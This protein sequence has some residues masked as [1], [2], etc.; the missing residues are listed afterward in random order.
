MS[1][2]IGVASVAASALKETG[3][4][5]IPVNALQFG[6]VA[7]AATVLAAD[8]KGVNAMQGM[9]KRFSDNLLNYSTAKSETNKLLL[10]MRQSLSDVIEGN[11]KVKGAKHEIELAF[12]FEPNNPV[13]KDLDN[14]VGNLQ[15]NFKSLSSLLDSAIGPGQLPIGPISEL[16]TGPIV[17]TNPPGPPIPGS[18]QALKEDSLK[19]KEEPVLDFKSWEDGNGGVY[20]SNTAFGDKYI[21]NKDSFCSNDYEESDKRVC[22]FNGDR[23]KPWQNIVCP[24]SGALSGDAVELRDLTDPTKVKQVLKDTLGVGSKLNAYSLERLR[25]GDEWQRTWAQYWLELGTN[26]LGAT[27]SRV[28]NLANEMSKSEN[29]NKTLI[30]LDGDKDADKVQR[31]IL[32]TKAVDYSY[33][34]PLGKLDDENGFGRQNKDAD[35]DNY[36]QTGALS[37]TETYLDGIYAPQRLQKAGFASVCAPAAVEQKTWLSNFKDI[38]TASSDL[39]ANLK[40]VDPI[41]IRDMLIGENS[42]MDCAHK[43]GECKLDSDVKGWREYWETMARGLMVDTSGKDMKEKHEKAVTG[44]IS[45]NVS[46]APIAHLDSMFGLFSV[47]SRDRGYYNKYDN[48]VEDILARG[49]LEAIQAAIL[50]KRDSSDA[51]PF[52]FLASIAILD[53][54]IFYNKYDDS[55]IR[56]TVFAIIDKYGL[57]REASG[58]FPAATSS[59]ELKANLSEPDQELKV[60]ERTKPSY[61]KNALDA[62]LGCGCTFDSNAEEVSQEIFCDSTS[63][64]RKDC[65]KKDAFKYA[66]LNDSK[67]SWH[68]FWTRLGRIILQTEPQTD[69]DNEEYM[70]KAGTRAYIYCQIAAYELA[71]DKSREEGGNQASKELAATIGGEISKILENI[72]ALEYQ[73]NYLESPDRHTSPSNDREQRARHWSVYDLD[74]LSL[75]GQQAARQEIEQKGEGGSDYWQSQLW[76][77]GG[78]KVE[79]PPAGQLQD[80]RALVSPAKIKEMLRSILGTKDG[81]DNYSMENLNNKRDW[82][83]F[84]QNLAQVVFGPDWH[85]NSNGISQ[86][87]IW[88]TD[89]KTPKSAYFIIPLTKLDN[90]SGTGWQNK[91]WPNRTGDYDNYSKPGALAN[92][93]KYID[94]VYAPEWNRYFIQSATANQGNAIIRF[95]ESY[96]PDIVRYDWSARVNK[97]VNSVGDLNTIVYGLKNGLS[98]QNPA[99]IASIEKDVKEFA[100]ATEK[101]G[102]DAADFMKIRQRDCSRWYYFWNQEHYFKQYGGSS[103]CAN[104]P[105]SNRSYFS[106][107]CKYPDNFDWT[108]YWQDPITLGLNW[109]KGDYDT[110]YCEIGE[111]TWCKGD[112]E[113]LYCNESGLTKCD[114]CSDRDNCNSQRIT[115]E[116]S[117]HPKC[118]VYIPECSWAEQNIKDKKILMDDC[119]AEKDES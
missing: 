28:K 37:N 59:V 20:V 99:V 49:D 46:L 34:W 36:A 73:R 65:E 90:E 81:G 52:A 116:N 38:F 106:Y 118:Y 92:T 17:W 57:T 42:V 33:L 104:C 115:L 16:N 105:C 9:L 56:K 66:V 6:A 103:N 48:P 100:D 83:V 31:A 12:F 14:M 78:C 71:L 10:G 45:K 58:L 76:C 2:S 35:I 25:D 41:Y 11:D 64:E 93:E 110:R 82:V 107:E 79:S 94:E 112:P 15:T 13:R 27:D 111:L 55:P 50:N 62:S 4:L 67:T 39:Q 119:L 80:L 18:W 24:S 63:N 47:E 88:L 109:C 40:L 95:S 98:P 89:P 85:D 87:Q 30:K 101:L 86:L 61:L 74:Q 5:P 51:K 72:T 32:E 69:C 97:V 23:V 21:R 53:D 3:I 75:A 113:A 68:Y 26:I 70:K 108:K 8:S 54:Q 96:E 43:S 84:W 77:A 22:M 114:C 102:L 60:A 7:G 29:R 44:C 117:V 19:R 1:A 91:K